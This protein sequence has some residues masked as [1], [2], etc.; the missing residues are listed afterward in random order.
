MATGWDS[1]NANAYATGRTLWGRGAG[2]ERPATISL[3]RELFLK[4]YNIAHSK[5]MVDKWN[6][7]ASG[8]R[9][10]TRSTLGPS[11]F[12]KANEMNGA[13]SVHFFF[14]NDLDAGSQISNDITINVSGFSRLSGCQEM[15]REINVHKSGA[16]Q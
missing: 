12:L 10:H 5:S 13:K 9:T 6:N 7:S 3:S 15:A 11:S 8:T 1:L 2:V 4:L 16:R 14:Q